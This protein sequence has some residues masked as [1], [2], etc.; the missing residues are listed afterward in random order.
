MS[1][2]GNFHACEVTIYQ[3]YLSEKVHAHKEENIAEK[4]NQNGPC[5]TDSNIKTDDKYDPAANNYKYRITGNFQGRKP[6]RISRFY[7]HLR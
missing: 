3:P 2:S 4:E 6:S 5:Y 1:R 7:N